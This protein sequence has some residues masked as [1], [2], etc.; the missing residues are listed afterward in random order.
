MGFG[1]MGYGGTGPVIQEPRYHT[2]S[3]DG[4]FAFILETL[5]G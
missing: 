3:E 4:R 5:R 1:G 2:G